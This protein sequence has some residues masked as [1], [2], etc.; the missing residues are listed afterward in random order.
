[1]G[2]KS[3]ATVGVACAFGGL[4]AS[5]ALGQISVP[6]PTISVPTVSVPT[7]TVPVPAPP[8]TVLTA[9]V[10]TPAVSVPVTTTSVQVTPS[11]PPASGSPVVDRAATGSVS[12]G[13]GSSTAQ[14]SGLAPVA[15]MPAASAGS[16]AAVAASAAS[17][18]APRGRSTRWWIAVRGADRRKTA[19]LVFGLGRRGAVEITV[20]QV[21]PVC[22]IAARFRV[23]GHAGT[24][25]VAVGAGAHGAQ[26]TP[27]TNRIVG[28]TPTGR[29]VLRQTIV[30]VQARA[31]SLAELAF[32][33]RSN[34]CRAGG[35]PGAGSQTA[36][37]A[38]ASFSGPAGL[39]QSTIRRHQRKSD[40]QGRA[41]SHGGRPIA[42]G[43]SDSV[44]GATTNPIVIALLVI[45]ALVFGVA[46]MPRT[47]V[48]GPRTMAAVATHRGE[49]LVTGAAVLAIAVIA[50]LLS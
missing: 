28:R 47:R 50:I 32:A 3:A 15:S 6:T 17:R 41:D 36:P 13:G 14:P 20:V 21:S 8:A 7:V 30:V 34:V 18:G 23:G 31:P 19:T 12:T 37:L 43:F 11:P 10:S 24:N 42:A 4:A 40:E 46:A 16:P 29:T 9:T 38:S 45:A 27:A 39:S 25:R 44:T 5:A 33:R 2:V 1:M 35:V 48:A 49:L 22:R 26:L